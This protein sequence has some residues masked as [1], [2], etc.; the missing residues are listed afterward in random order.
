[1]NAKSA[2]VFFFSFGDVTASNPWPLVLYSEY[3]IPDGNFVRRLSLLIAD[4]ILFFFFFFF[5]FLRG[6]GGG[7]A[8]G[9]LSLRKNKNKLR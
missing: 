2:Y 3:C 1:M 4:T 7:G 6:G 5:F 9:F 8:F